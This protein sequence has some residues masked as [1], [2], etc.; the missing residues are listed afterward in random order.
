M[1]SIGTT[2][3]TIIQSSK[4]RLSS[5]AQVSPAS[6]WGT[7]SQHLLLHAGSMH[8]KDG[9]AVDYS[10]ASFNKDLDTCRLSKQPNTNNTSTNW[11]AT[12]GLWQPKL[13]KE[14]QRTNGHNGK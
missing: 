5:T 2:H 12:T 14:P 6:R 8:A 1:S 13:G 10:V 11:P 9:K 7:S 4:S 3:A